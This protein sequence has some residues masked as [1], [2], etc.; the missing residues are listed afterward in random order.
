[1][2][3]PRLRRHAKWVFVLLAV[4]FGLGFV[5][6]GVGAGGIG[7]GDILRGGGGSSGVPSVSE[8]QKRVNEHPNDP[9]A[10]RDLATALETNGDTTDAISALERY[11]ALKPKNTNALRELASLYVTQAGAAQSRAQDAQLRAAYLATGGV[12]TQGLQL[13]GGAAQV[14]PITGA[15]NATIGKDQS[16]ALIEAQDAASKAVATYKRVAALEPSD[17]NVQLELAQTAQGTGDL[18]TAIA[19]YKK[20]L[21][22]APED[23][24]APLVRQQLKQL[25]SQQSGSKG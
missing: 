7:I 18:P 24:S 11:V 20:F 12:V 2:F 21:K 19:A 1:M 22:L 6:F 15:V 13:G 4:A 17:P 9:K 10:L 23:P 8:A 14:D 3:F 16:S 5:G 25:R